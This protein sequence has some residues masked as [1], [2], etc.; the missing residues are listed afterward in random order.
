MRVLSLAI[1]IALVSV[2]CGDD[3]PTAPTVSSIVV[4][5]ADPTETLFI[6]QTVQFTATH[7]QTGLLRASAER[8]DDQPPAAARDDVAAGG[9]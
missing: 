8:E 5:Q 3:S 2:G 4:A 6:G 1:A 9:K 7:P